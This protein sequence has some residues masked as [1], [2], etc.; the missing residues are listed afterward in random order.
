MQRSELVQ[1]RA[2]LLA[3]STTAARVEQERKAT[4]ER[5]AS[6]LRQTLATAREALGKLEAASFEVEVEVTQAEQ[7]R[8]RQ[9]GQIHAELEATADP[10]IRDFVRELQRECDDLMRSGVVYFEVKHRLTEERRAVSNGVAINARLSA[11]REAIRDAQ[12]LALQALDADEIAERLQSLQAS[13]PTEEGVS[14]LGAFWKRI[15]FWVTPSDG[16]WQP[17]RGE[18]PEL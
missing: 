2:A 6:Q 1:R 14:S 11:L 17:R 15:A 18:R 4:V 9:L 16:R 5:R 10:Q 8:Q 3:E 13:L 7:A 12:A